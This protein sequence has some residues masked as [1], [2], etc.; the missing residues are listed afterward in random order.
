M[1]NT[2]LTGGIDYQSGLYNV[3][4]LAGVTEVSFSIPIYDDDTVEANENFSLIIYTNSLPSGVIVGNPNRA[5][6]II[7]NDDGA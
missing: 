4:F 7:R 2:T 5:V 1:E 3:T 6:M